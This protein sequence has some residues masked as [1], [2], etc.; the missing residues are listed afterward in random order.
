VLRPPTL[1][2]VF[3]FRLWISRIWVPRRSRFRGLAS[4]EPNTLLGHLAEFRPKTP[5]PSAKPLVSGNGDRIPIR[6]SQWHR[7]TRAV[8][9][10]KEPRGLRR[11]LLE[12]RSSMLCLWGSASSAAGLF[13]LSR[14]KPR[15]GGWEWMARQAQRYAIFRAKSSEP[16]RRRNG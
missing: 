3:R 4:P 9:A 2:A 13:S 12:K 14:A 6:L 15:R 10:L 5:P 11:R 7:G 16:R 1:F 8:G